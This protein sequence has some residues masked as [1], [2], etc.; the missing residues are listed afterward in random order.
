[1]HFG[2]AKLQTTSITIWL[3][4]T[5]SDNFLRL[6]HRVCQMDDVLVDKTAD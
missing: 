4:T 2:Q 3:L 1:M 6:R 5:F